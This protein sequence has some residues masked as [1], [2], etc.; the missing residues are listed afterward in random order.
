MRCISRIF[1]LHRCSSQL[2]LLPP[3]LPRPRPRFRLRRTPCSSPTPA[4]RWVGG[5][6]PSAPAS[7]PLGARWFCI[8]S[9]TLLGW[10]S[11]RAT[12]ELRYLSIDGDD[13]CNYQFTITDGNYD[14]HD[15]GGDGGEDGGED[16]GDDGGEDGGGDDNGQPLEASSQHARP[17]MSSLIKVEV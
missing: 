6:R 2:P 3:P 12:D 7:P 1:H 8:G 9:W 5:S 11:A 16:S 17:S 14:G 15:A 4:S 13:R 10:E